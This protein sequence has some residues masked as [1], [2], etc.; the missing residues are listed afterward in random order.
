MGGGLKDR[1]T[2]W[3]ILVILLEKYLEKTSF[4]GLL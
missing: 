2:C 3:D 1:E 4:T